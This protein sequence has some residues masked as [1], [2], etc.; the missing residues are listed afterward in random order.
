MIIRGWRNVVPTRESKSFLYTHPDISDVQVI[1]VP[2]KRYGE[3]VMA[4][5]SC[6]RART[7]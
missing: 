4:W 1:G 2:A 3:E 6:A 5:S 7:P